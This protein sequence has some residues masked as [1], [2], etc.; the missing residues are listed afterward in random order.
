MHGTT[1]TINLAIPAAADFRFA[2]AEIF[3]GLSRA[4]IDGTVEAKIG[5]AYVDYYPSGDDD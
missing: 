4:A 1:L 5:E 2:A 3:E